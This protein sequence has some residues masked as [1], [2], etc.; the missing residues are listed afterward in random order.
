MPRAGVAVFSDAVLVMAHMPMR[1]AV[2]VGLPVSLPSPAMVLGRYSVPLASVEYW[3][4]GDLAGHTVNPGDP[5]TLRF[6]TSVTLTDA[7][8]AA[9]C[10]F[11]KAKTCAALKLGPKRSYSFVVT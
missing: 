9:S 3:A 2:P 10:A 1:R 8:C 5:A 4:A 6:W 7:G 11:E